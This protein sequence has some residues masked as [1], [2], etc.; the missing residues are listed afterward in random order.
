MFEIRIKPDEGI[1]RSIYCYEIGKRIIILLNF[2]KKRKRRQ[3]A[4]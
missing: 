1:A 4:Y 2:V 3:K